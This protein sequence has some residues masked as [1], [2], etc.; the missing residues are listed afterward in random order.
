MTNAR[1]GGREFECYAQAIRYRVWQADPD[2]GVHSDAITTDERGELRCLPREV[3][4][5]RVQREN[6]GRA[7]V[8]FAREANPIQEKS[9]N[10]SRRTR[11]CAPL[12]ANAGCMRFPLAATALG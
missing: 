11:P 3:K 7:A 9:A 8:W 10:S 6:L 2:A 4:Q 12:F 5:L 1:R